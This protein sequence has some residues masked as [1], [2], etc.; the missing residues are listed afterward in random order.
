MI[1]NNIQFNSSCLKTRVKKKCLAS[2]DHFLKI[3]VVFVLT[4]R[5]KQ[6]RAEIPSVTLAAVGNSSGVLLLN[7]CY[8]FIPR[9]SKHQHPRAAP[10]CLG[11]WGSA[12][13]C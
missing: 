13:S 8:I 9:Q 3:S 5:K 6:A 2:P 11:L 4:K 10:S 12:T 1:F 7:K